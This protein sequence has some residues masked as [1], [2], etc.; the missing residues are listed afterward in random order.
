MRKHSVYMMWVNESLMGVSPC[1]CAIVGLTEQLLFHQISKQQY[2]TWREGLEQKTHVQADPQEELD[3]VSRL[4]GAPGKG[5]SMP[6]S[7]T[8]DWP[9][10]LNGVHSQSPAL[11][12]LTRSAALFAFSH[13]R[14][15]MGCSTYRARRCT[16]SPLTTCG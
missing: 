14:P 6:K 13:R 12:C 9:L 16:W 15:P 3:N 11:P 7:A 8:L 5:Q 1:R 4:A 10:D 2:N